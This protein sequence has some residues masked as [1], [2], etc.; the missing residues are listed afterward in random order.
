MSNLDRVSTRECAFTQEL[1][2]IPIATVLHSEA[3]PER[4]RTAQRSQSHLLGNSPTAL[5]LSKKIARL[6][7]SKTSP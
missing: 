3:V 2:D 7:K 4:S 1:E 5:I 6:L